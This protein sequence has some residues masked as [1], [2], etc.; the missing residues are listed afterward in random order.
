MRDS[1]A[2]RPA[3]KPERYDSTAVAFHWTVAALILFLGALGLLFD[4]IPREA[5]PF[6]IN[7]HATVGLVYFGLL[8][9]R[10]VWRTTHRA[11]EPPARMGD[12][13]RRSSVA[14]HHLLY[15]LML[16]IPVLGIVAYVWHGRAF[17]YGVFQLDFGVAKDRG[18]YGPAEKIHELLAY[19]L[20]ALVGLHVAAAL[21][22]QYVKRDGVLVRMLPRGAG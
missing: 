4:E 22:H 10:V 12:V 8:I 2:G 14:V 5:R 16:A 15:L 7:L 11:P 19:A 13:M 17:D 20:F 9:A 1:V 18:V 3:A 6:W 21:W